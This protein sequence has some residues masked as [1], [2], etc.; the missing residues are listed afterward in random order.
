MDDKT[1]ADKPLVQTAVFSLSGIQR[2][3]RSE[4]RTRAERF[5]ISDLCVL[6]STAQS[7]PST[8]KSREST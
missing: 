7:F 2:G 1:L 4:V 3:R 6:T 8:G 5:L